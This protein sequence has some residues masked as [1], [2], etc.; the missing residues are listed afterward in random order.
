M[1]QSLLKQPKTKSN[2]CKN[3]IDWINT[4]QVFFACIICLAS[5]F[6]ISFVALIIDPQ[7][8]LTTAQRI[9]LK[10]YPNQIPASEALLASFAPAAE[11]I[12]NTSAIIVDNKN[13]GVPNVKECERIL[14]QSNPLLIA[15][16]A[17]LS[18]G[19]AAIDPSILLTLQPLINAAQS[20]LTTLASSLQTGIITTHQTG[21]FYISNAANFTDRMNSTYQLRSF[22]LPLGA[23]IYYVFIPANPQLLLIQTPS[24]GASLVFSD[25]WPPLVETNVLMLPSATETLLDGQRDKIAVAP[26]PVRFSER[27]YDLNTG[28]I[29]LTDLVHNFTAGSVVQVMSDI[30]MNIGLI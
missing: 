28:R 20:L 16:S 1:R 18:A 2:P 10:N 30:E 7:T 21:T 8:G 5:F 12:A 27:H 25:W 23:R 29:V 9:A 22:A 19:V 15:D 6:I 24:F 14:A 3:L 26:G 11:A 17:T 4:N 13:F